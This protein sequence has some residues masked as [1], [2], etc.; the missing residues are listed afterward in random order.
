MTRKHQP[1][2]PASTG[3]DRALFD[4]AAEE[5]RLRDQWRIVSDAGD[6]Q[7]ADHINGRM[8]RLHQ[9]IANTP[10]KMLS[11]ALLKLR[12]LGA[13]DSSSGVWDMELLQDVAAV[14]ERKIATTEGETA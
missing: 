11:G 14:M 1:E 12:R 7:L 3:P 13:W 5:E 10:A 4:S 9:F 6:E 8:R 2:G